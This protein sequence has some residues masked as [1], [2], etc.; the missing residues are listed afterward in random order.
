MSAKNLLKDIFP[1]LAILILG[2]LFIA[3][4]LFQHGYQ[5]SFVVLNSTYHNEITDP[6]AWFFT[7]LADATLLPLVMFLFIWHK[8]RPLV[9]S[10]ILVMLATGVITQ[11]LKH[12]FFDTWDRP[13]LLMQG[14]PGVYFV[15]HD[16]E[17][18]HSFPSGH[19]TTFGAGGLIFAWYWRKYKFLMQ[20]LVA[21]FTLVLCYT[22]VHLGVH[23]PGDILAGS[24]IGVGIGI[25][26]FLFFYPWCEKRFS[27][28]IHERL[29]SIQMYLLL[30]VVLFTVLRWVQ[31]S[32][33]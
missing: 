32:F 18:H 2:W 1:F 13:T 8:D 23:F 4:L 33:F 5:G 7:H 24:M 11:I 22:R 16:P 21:L 27:D 31:L 29:D 17:M 6:S 28:K 26:F 25:P 10:G 30:A 9:I 14:I 12:F 3:F 20:P 19:A 15:D